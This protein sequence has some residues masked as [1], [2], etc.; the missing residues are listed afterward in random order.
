M[1][2]LPL[3][4]LTPSKVRDYISCPR[5]YHLRYVER[6]SKFTSSPQVE[7]GNALHAAL[8]ELHSPFK[9][10]NSEEP[11]S[12]TLLAR[13]WNLQNITTEE[14]SQRYFQQAVEIL[15]CYRMHHSHPV[16]NVLGTELYLAHKVNVTAELKVELS[17]KI[18][19]LEEHSDSC[20]EI[21]DYKA[22]AN[23]EVPSAETLAHDLPTF[24]YYLLARIIY[25]GYSQVIVSQLNL[26]T[27]EKVSVDYSNEQRAE[28][29]QAFIALVSRLAGETFPPRR[30]PAC[31]W[32]GVKEFCM[33][34]RG[35]V[36]LDEL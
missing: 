12:Q 4:T 19:R 30:G 23:G 22:N 26:W 6:V 27:L 15:N 18:D 7:L 8:A 28:N 17:C 24:L 25:P 1:N 21:L 32:C 5:L 3:I 33:E 20:L 10:D 31:Q 2:S 29:K 13:C 16:G 11:D 34:Q 35:E 36:G 14:E 9:L